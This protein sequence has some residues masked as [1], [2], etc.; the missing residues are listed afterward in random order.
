M[1]IV[2]KPLYQV[3]NLFQACIFQTC[4]FP[5]R[6]V[7]LTEWLLQLLEYIVELIG[8]QFVVNYYKH[9]MAFPTPYYNF[10]IW[11]YRIFIGSKYS[12]YVVLIWF[13]TICFLVVIVRSFKMI[14]KCTIT[15]WI[16]SN[17]DIFC[18]KVFDLKNMNYEMKLNIHTGWSTGTAMS[19]DFVGSAL[20]N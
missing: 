6:R 14:V 12:K 16:R 11:I 7:Y 8:I 17:Y 3:V 19:Y 10:L 9:F 18:Q 13:K 5:I 20:L 15:D 4:N 1:D 2:I